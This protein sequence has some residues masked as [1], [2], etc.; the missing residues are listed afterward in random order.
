MLTLCMVILARPYTILIARNGFSPGGCLPVR[1]LVCSEFSELTFAGPQLKLIGRAA[2]TLEASLNHDDS[3]KIQSAITRG[4]NIKKLAQ[5]CP[6]FVPGKSLL[7]A[8]AQTS[9]T[10]CE[11]TSRYDSSTSGL[12]AFGTALNRENPRTGASTVPI[13]ATAGGEA[14]EA[15]RFTRLVR[16]NVGWHANKTIGLN[17]LEVRDKEQGWWSGHGG[18]IQQLS[19]AEHEGSSTSWLAVRCPGATTIFR[20]ILHRST[21]LPVP[22]A[23]TKPKV[24]YPVSRLDPNPIAILPT[25]RSGG[26]PHVDVSFNPWYEKQFAIIDEEGSWSIWNI[27]HQNKRRGLWTIK[28]GSAGNIHDGKTEGGKLSSNVADGWGSILWACNVNT[29][30]V[31]GRRT[32][33]LC[34]LQNASERFPGPDLALAKSVDWV[35]SVKRSTADK[36]YVFVVTSSRIF[37]L[38]VI[39]FGEMKEKGDPEISVTI[40]LSWRHFRDQEDI[41]LELTVLG[42]TERTQPLP[43]TDSVNI[44][45]KSATLVI[46]YSRLTGLTTVYSGQV[47]PPPL[48]LPLSNSDPYVLSLSNSVDRSNRLN[49]A[50]HL[51]QRKPI[52]TLVLRNLDY[53][54]RSG[55]V[56]SGPGH[57]Y[58]KDNIRFYQ[59]LILYNDLSVEQSL[60]ALTPASRNTPIHSPNFK[61]QAEPRGPM[62]VI[63][64]S[65]IVPNRVSDRTRMETRSELDDVRNMEHMTEESTS[66]AEDPWTVNF[67]WLE[68]HM[69]NFAVSS[70]V[71]GNTTS[72]VVTSFGDVLK[73]I[74]SALAVEPISSESG[75]R[76]LYVYYL[77]SCG[78]L[79]NNR[80]S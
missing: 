80:T 8:L 76:L 26:A 32:F 66:D 69:Q 12:L 33:A 20:P 34:N 24:L 55:S 17:L 2:I 59:L 27:E 78:D 50:S 10:V 48:K 67:Q 1:T 45:S 23:P 4:R 16:K 61:I 79:S 30:L 21:T 43:G 58:L 70:L 51:I 72:P 35:L 6:E 39:G 11:I 5:A 60:Y 68:R 29:V 56:P 42:N 52:S 74:R 22:V 9:E 38:Q 7:P 53:N 36:S 46:L 37:W 31:F 14:G 64:E 15:V 57:Q 3:S 49:T 77:I 44:E 71:V 62:K 18:P 13:I 19:F 63:K 73:L 65:F 47:S 28:A 25:A 75:I 40:L 41:S 54:V